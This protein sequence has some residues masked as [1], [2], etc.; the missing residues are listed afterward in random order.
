MIRF[1]KNKNYFSSP[2]TWDSRLGN[3]NS[4]ALAFAYAELNE[5]ELP[6]VMKDI[7]NARLRDLVRHAYSNVK[8]YKNIFDATKFDPMG[9]YGEE[10]LAAITPVSKSLFRKY[11]RGYTVA[12]NIDIKRRREGLTSGSTGEPFHYVG[13]RAYDNEKSVLSRRM[14]RWAKLDHL[15]PKIYCSTESSRNAWPNMTFLHPHFIYS[16][17]YEYIATIR[18]LQAPAVFGYPLSTFELLWMLVENGVKDVQFK[19]AIFTGHAVS[20]GIRKFFRDNFGGEVFLYYGAMEIGV[21]AIECEEHCGM[22]IQEENTIIEI[23]DSE[24]RAV[25]PGQVGRVL[26]TYLSNEVMPFIRYDI[27]DYGA[28]VPG[29]CKCGRKSRRIIIEGRSNENL[30]VGDDGE[31]IYPGIL[32]DLLDGY[33][34]Y[35]QR[36]QLIQSDLNHF[37]LSIVPTSLYSDNVKPRMIQALRAILKNSKID[38]SVADN[39]LPLPNGKFQYFVSPFWEKKFPKDMLKTA[40]LREGMHINEFLN[41]T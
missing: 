38:F 16:R 40:I 8:L 15:V 20:S 39:I 29:E 41:M 32:R 17:R 31:I 22:H 18:A 3:K 1:L 5:Y 25:R 37:C 36:Y 7:R 14:W 34:D 2:L 24:G 13:D 35:F 26:I 11:D 4:F 33:F 12:S 21:I 10:N 19:I 28:I 9:F 27:G 30:F 23:V 6:Q